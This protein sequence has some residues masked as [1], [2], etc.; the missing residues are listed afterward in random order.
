MSGDAPPA[1]PLTTQCREGAS[2][3]APR[4][5]NPEAPALCEARGPSLFEL[6]HGPRPLLRHVAVG[7]ADGLGPRGSKPAPCCRGAKPC[8]RPR[9]PN[10]VWQR[11]AQGDQSNSR[12][13]S[14]PS[15]PRRHRASPASGPELRSQ[16][17]ERLAFAGPEAH[18]VLSTPHTRSACWTAAPR[19]SRAPCPKS[20]FIVSSLAGR[21][22]RRG[23]PL[24]WLSTTLS[25]CSGLRDLPY[26]AASLSQGVQVLARRT[27]RSERRAGRQEAG[28]PLHRTLRPA[29]RWS[30]F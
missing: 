22:M 17:D 13:S 6:R 25:V 14:S 5:P 7:V 26:G 12:T 20:G 11:Y 15:H 27:P 29:R 21:T 19:A 24:V 4:R 8:R 23:T 10:C 3:P 9:G 30:P 18:R 2:P 16:R 1:T 28:H